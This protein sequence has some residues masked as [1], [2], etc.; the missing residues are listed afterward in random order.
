MDRTPEQMREDAALWARAGY[1]AAAVGRY[2]DAADQIERL[3]A[4]LNRILERIAFVE[5]VEDVRR[6]AKE[7]LKSLGSQSCQ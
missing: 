5:P 2:R 3:R 4:V 6:I 7:A 1:P